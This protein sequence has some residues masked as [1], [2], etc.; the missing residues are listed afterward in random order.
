VVLA[1]LSAFAL[2]RTRVV[3]VFAWVL[4]GLVCIATITTGWHYLIDVLAGLVLSAAAL[5]LAARL[6]PDRPPAHATP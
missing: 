5:W 3:R 2:R 1:V 4:C 6:E